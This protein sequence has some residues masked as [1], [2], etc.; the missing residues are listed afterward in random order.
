V[1]DA[2]D[3]PTPADGAALRRSHATYYELIRNN[4]F[5]VYVVDADFRLREVSLGARKVFENVRPLL[6]R[7][8]A[9]V[10]RIVWPE[11]FASEAIGRFRHTL[12]SGEAYTAA[13]TVERRGDIDAVEAYDWRIERVTLPDGRFGVV[14]YFYDWT[15]LQQLDTALR[16]SEERFRRLAD[17]MPQLVWI[18]EDAGAVIYYNSRAE[19]Y[20]GLARGADGRW[21]WRPVLHPEDVART[22]QVWAEAVASGRPYECEHRTVMADGRIRWHLSR[23]LPVD[24]PEGRQWFGT[25]TDIDDLKAAEAALRESDRR[26]DEFL[27]TLAHELRNPLAP[28]R[29][30]LAVLESAVDRPAAFA[31]TRDMMARQVDHLVR[32]IDDLLDVSRITRGKVE[33]ARRRIDLVEAV[34]HGIEIARPAL[35]ERA[36]TATLPAA[37]VVVEGDAVR[38]AQVVAN[39]LNNAGKFTP[40][41]AAI[42]LGLATDGDAALI[43]VA[44]AGIGIPPSQLESIFGLFRQLDTGL[45]RGHGGLG[46]GLSLVR[47]LV[48]L[49]G[50]SVSAASEGADRGAT[51]EVRLP[52]APAHAASLPEVV[53][54]APAATPS[55][56]GPRRVLIV[57]DNRDAADSLRLLLAMDGHET[58]AAYDG[59]SALALARDFGPQVVLLDIGMPGMD[60]HAVCRALRS[61]P[62]HADA[63]VVALTGWGQDADRTAALAAGFDAHLVKPVDP[64]T[65]TATIASCRRG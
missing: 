6:D 10:L 40:A 15:E 45:A 55:T 21:S 56:A 59:P 20:R 63:I 7:D 36:F 23:A 24:G 4:P 37:P 64:A 19:A 25:A 29:S 32:L 50:G 34:R 57:D 14:C 61:E 39:L 22:A 62:R 12:A 18:A 60:G 46:I 5:G 30:A 28:L 43:R 42:R 31:A 53:R 11:P 52:L 3:V 33:L 54:P 65:V 44:D 9:E 2:R 1:E 16:A 49:H 17:A 13:R 8:F 26:K 38:L 47:E 51:F 35:V 41:G 48:E 27:A 58:V